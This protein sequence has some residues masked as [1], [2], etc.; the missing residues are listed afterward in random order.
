MSHANTLD[1]HHPAPH[2]PPASYC[3]SWEGHLGTAQTCPLSWEPG[4]RGWQL[5]AFFHTTCSGLD[6]QTEL[7]GAGATF[8]TPCVFLT[9][10]MC[11]C[12]LPSVGSPWW[13]L[14][15]GRLGPVLSTSHSSHTFCTS[16]KR[17][18]DSRTWRGAGTAGHVPLL[19]ASGQ[20]GD[21]AL[22]SWHAHEPF[23]PQTSSH[24]KSKPLCHSSPSDP[25]FTPG[26]LPAYGSSDK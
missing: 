25:S 24:A 11:V 12:R 20:L 18:G 2:Q 3:L 4:P 15:G 21:P 1:C 17:I 23:C 14:G 26:V 9:P 22:C 8:S 10:V 6:A 13:W 19:S 16:T 7:M 5:S